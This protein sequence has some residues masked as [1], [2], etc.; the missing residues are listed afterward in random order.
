MVKDEIRAY[1]DIPEDRLH[2]I[3]SGIDTNIFH[4]GLQDEYRQETRTRYNIPL[5]AP[6]FLFVGSGFERKD[7]ARS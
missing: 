6:L 5:D 1:F 3:Y 2:V 4:P 7:C